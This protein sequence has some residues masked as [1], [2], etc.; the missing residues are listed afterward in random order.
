MASEQTERMV[1][2]LAYVARN[3]ATITY[4]EFAGIVGGMIARG[5]GQKLTKEL[6]PHCREQGLPPLWALV[7][8]AGTGQSSDPEVTPADLAHCYSFKWKA[9]QD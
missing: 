7:V 5:A 9:P 3:K 1:R 4:G 8:N 6:A 2:L